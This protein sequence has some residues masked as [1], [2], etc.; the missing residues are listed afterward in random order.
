MSPH[1]ISPGGKSTRS[2]YYYRCAKHM[3]DS[4]DGYSNYR[5]HHAEEL[6]EQVWQEL[7]WTATPAPVLLLEGLPQ[8]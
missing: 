2:Y 1:T 6:E 8:I 5:H 3:K 4:Y 7:L